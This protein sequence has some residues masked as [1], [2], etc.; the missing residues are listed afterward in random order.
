MKRA[1]YFTAR[2][3]LLSLTFV[4]SEIRAMRRLGWEIQPISIHP[5]GPTDRLGE[6]NQLA[7]QE[8]AVL[9]NGF[10]SLIASQTR[11]IGRHPLRYLRAMG[12]SLRH[13]PWDPKHCF[14]NLGYFMLGVQLA[15]Y[16]HEKSL[17]HVHV[18]LANHAAWIA[19]AACRF[20]SRLSY[21][22][23][24][25]GP[26]EFYDAERS[27]IRQKIA[28]ARWIRC[29]SEFCRSQVMA[30]SDETDWARLYVI[31]CGIS[32]TEF[33]PTRTTRK[34]ESA[35]DLE[36]FKILAIGRWV[37]L[38]GFSVLLRACACLEQQ[39][40][41][42]KLRIAGAGPEERN[43]R[44]LASAL[45]LNSRVEWIGPL[46]PESVPS[47]IL[48]NHVLAL[49]S[50][51]EGIPMVLMEALAS[52]VTVV[53][54]RIAGIPEL[55]EHG[56]QGLL[57]DPGSV[58]ALAEALSELASNPMRRLEMARAGA[59]KVRAEFDIREIALR[60]DAL[61]VAMI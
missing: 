42:F 39:G 10:V 9:F 57:V 45:G 2:Y 11:A 54:T 24:I 59:V 32:L 35:A 46:A 51:M 55:I 27:L 31:H 53:A 21:S 15:A 1:A 36:P 12:N 26:D 19:R 43:L 23:S 20:D 58:S 29:I 41:P 40:L 47:E 61:L 6:R 5:P 22:V 33:A 37:P 38:K 8:T 60:L 14:K 50:F 16:L 34:L 48:A 18:H 3:P 49:P 4:E 56:I 44:Y 52:E 28:D 13:G 30:W 25:H 17:K 7:A